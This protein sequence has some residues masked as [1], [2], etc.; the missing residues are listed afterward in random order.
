MRRRSG[1]PHRRNRSPTPGR[2]CGSRPDTRKRRQRA[3]LLVAGIILV[4]IASLFTL[5][6]FHVLAAQSAFSLDRLGKERTNEQL[7][8]E[9]LREQVAW[10]QAPETVIDEATK[11]GMQQG[12]A[13][14]FLSAPLAAPHTAPPAGVPKQD[15]A[16][17][18]LDES[19]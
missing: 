8:Y 11:L 16:K 6:S 12:Q 10:L 7:R 13:P 9:R 4:T 14:G 1:E 17:K 3:R 15:P 5:V 19:P 18:H 2:N